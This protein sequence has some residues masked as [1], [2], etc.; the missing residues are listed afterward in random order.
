MDAAFVSVVTRFREHWVWL[1]NDFTATTRLVSDYRLPL[2]KILVAPWVGS[3]HPLEIFFRRSGFQEEDTSEVRRVECRPLPLLRDP[4][5][6]GQ[7]FDFEARQYHE[8]ELGLRCVSVTLKSVVAVHDS[9][10]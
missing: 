7:I 8:K 4:D 1:D 10:C 2:V 9:Q 5:G 3:Y 6:A